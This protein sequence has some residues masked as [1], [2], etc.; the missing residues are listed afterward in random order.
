MSAGSEWIDS[1]RA[2]TLRITNDRESLHLTKLRRSLDSMKTLNDSL[3]KQEEKKVKKNLAKLAETSICGPY[4]N[5]YKSFRPISVPKQC[6]Q[7]LLTS[8]S[9][10]VE[11][12]GSQF[13]DHL[14]KFASFL[15]QPTKRISYDK[16]KPKSFMPFSAVDLSMSA[17]AP[18][19]PD[20]ARVINT[21]APQKSSNLIRKTSNQR[22]ISQE[23]SNISIQ[24]AISIFPSLQKLSSVGDKFPNDKFQLYDIIFG[25]PAFE[26]RL[27]EL[28]VK[29]QEEENK[30]KLDQS[31]PHIKPEEILRCRYLRLSDS[32]ISTLLKLCKDSGVHI[33]IHPHMKESEIDIHTVISPSCYN[34]V[35]L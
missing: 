21:Y 27:K 22:N 24:E 14:P 34:T 3:L 11:T 13:S 7:A 35:S 31:L 18:K 8:A 5:I 4:K 2:K 1:K 33:D 17:N 19:P 28:L 30:S 15:R 29:A 12:A 26:R 9:D 16:K 10:S 20:N 23:P 6:E 25:F 32:N